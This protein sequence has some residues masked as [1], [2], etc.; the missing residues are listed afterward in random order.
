MNLLENVI[1]ALQGLAANKLRSAL[2]M[3]G[4]II[5]VLAVILGTSIGQGSRDQVLERIQ[6]MGSNVITVYAGEQRSGAVRMGVGSSQTM[7]LE[8]V[9]VIRRECP[10]V[11][12][13]APRI[14]G[15]A[16]VKFGNRNTNTTILGTTP[17]YF[18]IRNYTIEH[19]QGFTQRDVRGMRKVCIL[20]KTVALNL[21][22]DAAPIGK[23][24]RIKGIGFKIIGLMA[25]KGA[26]SFGDADDQVCIPVT[27]GMKMVFGQDYIERIYA[28]A[29]SMEKTAQAVAEIETVLKKQ[30]K[31][32]ANR[33]PDFSVRTQAE[34]IQTQEQASQTFTL[35]LT[36]IAAVALLV[37]GIGIMNIMLVS[38]TERTREIGIRKAVGARSLNILFQFLIE[39]M[40]LSLLGG[41]IGIGGG[42][43]ASQL[44]GS[45]V[46]WRIA[47]STLWMG[48]AFFSSATIGIF[49]GIY[50]AWKAAQLNPIEALR[51]E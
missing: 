41:V 20:G 38:V 9:D 17:D 19:G 39:S 16:Q 24:L 36:G 1:V 29:A 28:Q 7:T 10:S 49:F 42:I 3:L 37:G 25:L 44:V 15:S 2:T 27:T 31:I 22:D 13:A 21:F 43:L 46:G 40:T 30:H 5:G 45:W 23:S 6:S 18:T 32:P 11:V 12:G 47:V 33:D 4:I 35:L 51:Y 50:P 34:F 8:D 48:I 26:E 14:R